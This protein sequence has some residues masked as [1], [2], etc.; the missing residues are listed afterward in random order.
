MVEISFLSLNSRKM[1]NFSPKFCIFGGQFCDVKK[2]SRHICIFA[3][4]TFCYTTL[5][6][7]CRG[8]GDSHGDSCGYGMGMGIEMP[9]PRQAALRCS[10]SVLLFYWLAPRNVA[11]SRRRMPSCAHRAMS[12]INWTSTAR[13][14]FAVWPGIRLMNVCSC[15]RWREPAA[16]RR[17]HG[18]S[19]SRLAINS[20]LQSESLRGVHRLLRGLAAATR[21]RTRNGQEFVWR[22]ASDHRWPGAKILLLPLISVAARGPALPSNHGPA[23]ASTP[24]DAER[25]Q[26]N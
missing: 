26:G 15:L 23:I 16:A 21:K 20:S 9:S 3:F 5:Y 8:Y 22:R 24:G 10:G 14:S 17:R 18:H 4:C 2:I 19:E 25:C 12:S 7:G 6:Q 11:D 13:R 1:G